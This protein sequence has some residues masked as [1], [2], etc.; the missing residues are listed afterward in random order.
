[1]G[2]SPDGDVDYR[3]LDGKPLLVNS[4]VDAIRQWKF[5]PNVVQGEVTWSRVRALVRFNADGTTAIDLAHAILPDNFGDPGIPS[6]DHAAR[7]ASAVSKPASAPECK[8]LPALVDDSN[9]AQQLLLTA[10][11][12]ASLFHKQANPFQLDLDFVA[13][14]NVPIQGHLTLKWESNDRWWRKIVMGDFEQTEIRN[15]DRQYTSR[16]ISFKPIRTV[17]LINLLQFADRSEGLLA[18]KQ[19]QRVENGVEMICLQAEQGFSP[20]EICI[21][22]PSLEILRDEWQEPPD[23]RRR[24]EYADYFDFEGHRYPRKLQLLVNGSK[25]ITANVVNLTT[26]AF[27]QTLLVAP[28]GAIERRQCTDMKP[29]MAIKKPDPMY[30]KSASQ[31]KLMGDTTVA[32]TVLTDGSVGDIQLIGGATR[33]MDDATLQTLKSWRFKPAMCGA[34]PVVSDIEVVVS[35]RLR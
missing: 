11:Q 29:P 8:S 23:Q 25:V 26:A 6:T 24:E 34:D 17:E 10:K 2:I 22:S 32:M 27:D 4:A 3:V 18:K 16:N 19:K 5:Q 1:L 15:G 28:K 21:N 13:Q 12:Q 14:I 30:P 20:H 9:A 35:F 7:M 33:S 31:D